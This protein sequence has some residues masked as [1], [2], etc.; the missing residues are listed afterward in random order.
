MR[1]RLVTGEPFHAVSSLRHSCDPQHLAQS[2]KVLPGHMAL[3]QRVQ[4]VEEIR[5]VLL[6]VGGELGTGRCVLEMRW[7]SVAVNVA[8]MPTDGGMKEVARLLLLSNF[9]PQNNS[10]WGRPL[11]LRG[12]GNTERR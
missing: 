4:L 5:E 3:V 10:G 6:K 2:L 9:C 8:E 11:V 1:S 7:R 12:R